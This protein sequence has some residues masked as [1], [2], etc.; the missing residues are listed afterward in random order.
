MS[1]VQPVGQR[2]K[3]LWQEFD[4]LVQAAETS[5]VHLNSSSSN[6]NSHNSI[7]VKCFRQQSQMDNVSKLL[8]V[9]LDIFDDESYLSLFF[10]ELMSS[11][12][13]GVNIGNVVCSI[14]DF[15]L[16]GY[17]S[18]NY[19]DVPRASWELIF[20]RSI[21]FLN[22]LLHCSSAQQANSI[23]MPTTVFR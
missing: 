3:Q 23:P 10:V 21:R 16:L 22:K 11:G 4:K 20:V 12:S 14:L 6:G 2:A 13:S 15:L 17:Y 9:F 1:T 19:W 18:L 7:A 8:N 5:L